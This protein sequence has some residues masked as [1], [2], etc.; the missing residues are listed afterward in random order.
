MIECTGF[1]KDVNSNITKIFCDYLPDTK[2]G[3]P[4]ADAIKVK[5]NIHWLSC[6]Y[7]VNAKVNLYDRL[8]KEA[9]PGK[10][11]N[12]LDDLN[13]NSLTSKE[14]KI[15]ENLKTISPGDQ[16]QFER[17]GYFIADDLSKS[18]DIILNRTTTLRDNWQ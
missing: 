8:F 6:K 1:E 9:H 17:H 4:G 2:S 12:Y 18:E 7:A 15:E 16:Y 10:N 14:I 5:G 11:N 13:P 3:T